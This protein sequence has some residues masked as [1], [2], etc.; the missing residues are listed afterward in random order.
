M[1]MMTIT[2]AE[3]NRILNDLKSANKLNL[4]IKE[5]RDAFIERLKL[6]SVDIGKSTQDNSPL[7]VS[8]FNFEFTVKYVSELREVVGED[9][10][11][12]ASYDFLDMFVSASISRII[13]DIYNKSFSFYIMQIKNEFSDILSDKQQAEDLVSYI[14]FEDIDCEFQHCFAH[15]IEDHVSKDLKKILDRYWEDNSK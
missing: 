14:F 1:D 15:F 5:I 10:I 8:P 7:F 2:H 9:D 12:K 13:Q 6:L 3:F 4:P 11:H